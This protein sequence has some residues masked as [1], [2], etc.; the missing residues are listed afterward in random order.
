MPEVQALTGLSKATLHYWW[1]FLE[2]SPEQEKYLADKRRQS[3]KQNALNLVERRRRGEVAPYGKGA[4][5]VAQTVDVRNARNALLAYRRA[6]L[7][8]KKALEEI[9]HTTFTKEIFDGVV[10]EE[11]RPVSVDMVI[12][13]AA[14]KFLIAVGKDEATSHQIPARFAVVSSLGDKRQRIAFVNRLGG[15]VEARLKKL[16]VR[17][18]HVDT[19]TSGD[20]VLA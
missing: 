19:L 5:V 8:V 15:I 11:G 10:L 4:K 6:E 14:K 2:L 12:P 20:L 16:R 9:Y 7:P 17:V 13:F 1:S 18:L 3:S